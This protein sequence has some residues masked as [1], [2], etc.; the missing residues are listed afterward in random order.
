MIVGS[1]LD[2]IDA[3]PSWRR[4]AVLYGIPALL[5]LYGV[6]SAERQYGLSFPKPLLWIGDISYSI[7]LTHILVLAS[8]GRLW[9][10]VRQDGMLDNIAALLLML[11]TVIL[12][13]A[14]SYR[15]FEKP[16]Q[17]FFSGLRMKSVRQPGAVR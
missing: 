17:E 6:V 3:D 5:I 15:F 13:G 11:T 10:K 9:A 16:M 2:P 7:Y 12:A 8:M 4:R 14:L 1:F